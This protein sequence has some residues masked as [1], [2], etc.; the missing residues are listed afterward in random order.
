M[1][2]GSTVDIHTSEESFALFFS[3]DVWQLIVDNTNEYATKKISG[4]KVTVVN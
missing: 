3:S 2:T 4:M 1:T